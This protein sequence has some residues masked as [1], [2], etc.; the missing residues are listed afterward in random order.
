MIALGNFAVHKSHNQYY[1]YFSPAQDLFHS[2]TYQGLPV[3]YAENINSEN[4]TYDRKCPV[5]KLALCETLFRH[6][7]LAL[8][9]FQTNISQDA[10]SK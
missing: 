4:S 1:V 8:R 6:A 9:H 5:E 2:H 10:E 3:A 7:V